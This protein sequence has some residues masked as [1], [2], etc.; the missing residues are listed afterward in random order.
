MSLETLEQRYGDFYVPAFKVVVDRKD[1][2]RDLFLTVTAAEVDLKEKA[3]GRFSF[4]V[5]NAFDW[6]SRAFVAGEGQQRTKLLDLF[7]FGAAV[8]IHFGYSDKLEEL[9]Q[10]MVTEVGTSFTEGSIPELTISGYDKL[11]PLTL[12]KN[13]K[14][15]EEVP[16]STAVS[17][18][19]VATTLSTKITTTTPKRPRID[20][21]Q[22]TDM[23]FLG[24]LAKN[25]K[26]T[27]YV[28]N[29]T[30]HFGPRENDKKA[31]LELGWGKGLLT[32]SP[33]GSLTGQIVEVEVIGESAKTGEPIVGKAK[34]GVDESGRDAGAESG[35]QRVAS[36]LGSRKPKLRVRAAVQTQAEADQ[37]AK[38]ILEERSQEFLKGTGESIGLPEIVPGVNLELKD[39]GQDFSRAYYVN[40]AKH[41]IDGSGY[42]TS[43]DVEETSL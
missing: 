18:I 17:D 4:T 23:S 39:L 29:G 31:V 12:G 35:G 33:V 37:R 27:F 32:F 21:S 30:F 28:R 11:Y 34:A 38:A 7:K 42:R 6:T 25:N 19:A 20:Q 43:F 36:A 2:V 26:S 3:A 15:W 1:L 10:G 16:D 5:A 14:H 8:E 9:I 22:E 24:K 41:K 13:T 40:G